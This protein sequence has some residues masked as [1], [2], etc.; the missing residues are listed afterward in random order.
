MTTNFY[1]HNR[2]SKKSTLIF[3]HFRYPKN[4]LFIASTKIKVNPKGWNSKKK[5]IKQ[6]K[7]TPLH[8]T[9]NKTLDKIEDSILTIYHEANLQEISVSNSYLR[10]QLNN[11]M[12]V[13]NPTDVIAIKPPLTFIDYFNIF[14]TESIY[15]IRLKK[16]GLPINKTTLA[17]YK[18]V[19]NQL[20]HLKHAM[21]IDF[22]LLTLYTDDKS[23]I[24]QQWKTFFKKYTDYLYDELNCFDNTVSSRVKLINTFLN[25]LRDDKGLNIGDFHN[26]I[27]KV[28]REDI[29]V[30]VITPDQLKYLIHNEDFIKSIPESL[31]KT[32]DIFILG[33]T[34]A[35]RISDLLSLKNEN[36]EKNDESL[37]LKVKSKKTKTVTQI[38]LP[39]YAIDIV[40]KYLTAENA[41]KLFGYIHLHDFNLSL[42]EL[43]KHCNW[44]SQ[45]VKTRMKRGKE[46]SIY[47]DEN[48]K[49]HFQLSDIISSHI[50]RR[51]GISNLLLMGVPEYVV[52]EIS[53]H[54]KNSVSFQRYVKLTQR[55]Q[56]EFT[57]KAFEKFQVL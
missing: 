22:E 34:T 53:G 24:I 38:K 30:I 7:N 2:N 12:N 40:N 50:M 55:Y 52:R 15:Q 8:A 45:V 27:F 18:V 46:V 41:K 29:P 35:L 43:A 57:D 16:D 28:K 1:L 32:K 36:F 20:L 14:F 17:N 37:Y 19:M 56:D 49:S 26:S 42:K 4:N 9:Y 10:Q 5:R 47:K 11:T 31:H 39:S 3:L 44:N 54:S 13:E 33:C 51:T 21:S 48:T 6:Y 25:Y 23:R